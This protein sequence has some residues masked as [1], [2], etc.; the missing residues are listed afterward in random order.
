[1]EDYRRR[2]GYLTQRLGPAALA[3][4]HPDE[5]D[6]RLTGAQLKRARHKR[7]GGGR[8]GSS[9]R[10]RQARRDRAAWRATRRLELADVLRSRRPDRAPEPGPPQTPWAR[11]DADIAGDLARA[12][13]PPPGALTPC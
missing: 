5:W 11:P 12:A 6:A 3:G 13:V 1:M 4:L 8:G 2:A 9:A 7:L 10:A